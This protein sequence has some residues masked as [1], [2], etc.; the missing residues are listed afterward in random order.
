MTVS[1]IHFILASERDTAKI[2]ERLFWAV[3]RYRDAYRLLPAE[4]CRSQ[5]AVP[6]RFDTCDVVLIK[7]LLQHVLPPEG[8]SAVV[9]ELFRFYVTEDERSFAAEVYM[10]P[11]DIR[12][13]YESGMYIG[14]HGYSHVRLGL[15]GRE[16]QA[17]EVDKALAFLMGITGRTG[18]W[19]MCYP[20]GSYNQEL[21]AILRE[22][23]C[24][25]GLTTEV[26][27]AQDPCDP[28][29]LPRLDTNDLP[30]R[31]A[32]EACVWTQKAG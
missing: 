2:A 31:A 22:R 14:S 15:L 19:I 29:I 26:A 13:M 28:L 30:K 27:L 1:K 20:Y 10:S 6:S 12:S 17:A 23:G 24:G 5:W 7:L 18:S 3:A 16:E 9:D 4:T 32:A 21:L 25:A 8:R 11:S